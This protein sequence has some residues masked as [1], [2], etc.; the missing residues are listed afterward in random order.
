MREQYQTALD[1]LVKDNAV[2]AKLVYD[3]RSATVR[4]TIGTIICPEPWTKIPVEL[5]AVWEPREAERY[6][7]HYREYNQKMSPGE[8]TYFRRFF[9]GQLMKKI[10]DDQAKRIQDLGEEEALQENRWTELEFHIRSN[11]A[12]NMEEK[13]PPS[14]EDLDSAWLEW[15][16][17]GLTLIATESELGKDAVERRAQLSTWARRGRMARVPKEI[18][19]AFPQPH[20]R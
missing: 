6:L 12:L 19:Y 8:D 3:K 11:V 15:E 13:G 4:D 5:Y 18:G 7:E 16:L 17:D 14:R 20:R 10:E 9:L 2:K 1:N